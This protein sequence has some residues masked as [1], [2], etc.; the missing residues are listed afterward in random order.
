MEQ[1]DIIKKYDYEEISILQNKKAKLWAINVIHDT[2]RGPAVGG[3]RF[4]KYQNEDEA[5]DDALKLARAM[6]YKNAAADLS[7]GGGKTVIMDIEGMDRTLAL[8]TVGRFIESLQGR[9]YTGRD[10]GISVEDIEVMRTETQWVADEGAEGVGD[11]SE[12]TAFG[13][14]RAIQAC[15]Q[16]VYGSDSL[17]GKKI[18]VQGVGG[19]GYWVTKYALENGAQVTVTDINPIALERAK[20]AFKAD[21]VPPDQIYT[22]DCDVFSP[23]AVGGVINSR[24]VPQLK[25]KIVAGCANNTLEKE[26]DGLSLLEKGIIYA[27]DYIINSGAMIQWWFRQRTYKITDPRDGREVISNL[28]NVVK[29]ILRISKEK[30]LAP[31]RVAAQ[32]A[33]SKLKKEKTYADMHWGEAT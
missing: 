17:V 14:H 27:P 16:E 1:V 2:S 19:V 5:L 3:T 11:L 13:V 29:H 23:C 22:V 24:T 25:C 6:T 20:K 8:K 26:D 33:E 21:S 10:L 12:A 28:Y 31:F 9:R 15:L 30:K 4:M 7:C 32:Y 18:A